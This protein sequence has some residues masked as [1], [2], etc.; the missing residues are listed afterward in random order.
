MPFAGTGQATGQAPWT[1]APPPPWV[2]LPSRTDPEPGYEFAGHRAGTGRHRNRGQRPNDDRPVPGFEFDGSAPATGRHR[3]ARPGMSGYWLTPS[4]EVVSTS[5]WDGQSIGDQSIDDQSI[6]GQGTGPR[7]GFGRQPAHGT[8]HGMGRGA[9]RTPKIAVTV[10]ALAAAISFGIFVSANN[11]GPAAPAATSPFAGPAFP[12][13]TFA[14]QDFTP[15]LAQSTRGITQLQGRVASSGNEVVAV[16]A[17]TGQL[18][19]RAQFFVSLNDGRSWTLGNVTAPGGGAPPPGYA[20]QFVA[21]GHGRWVAVGPYALWTSPDGRTWTLTEDGMP[22]RPGDRITVLKRTSDGFIAAGASSSAGSSPLVLLSATGSR[23]TRLGQAQLKLRAAGGAGA[24]AGADAGGRVA[25]IRLA[26]GDRGS[27]LIAGDVVQGGQATARTGGAWL[28]TDGGKSWTAV[29][30]PLGHGAQPEF[31]DLI[32][33]PGDG[34]LMVR[35]AV[36]RGVPAADVYQ[37]ATGTTWRFAAT[38]TTPAGFTA[39]LMNGGPDGAVL[40]GTAGRQLIVFVSRDG[41]AWRQTAFSGTAATEAVSGVAVTDTSAVIAAG[42]SAAVP[43]SSQRLVTVDGMTGGLRSVSLTAIPGA[44]E[45]QLAV[46][47]VAAHGSTQIAVGSAN[48]FPAAWV[49]QDAGVT[50]RRATGRAAGVLD[51]RGIQQLTSVT[52]GGSGWLAVGVPSHTRTM[53][54]LVL[55]SADGATWSVV[56]GEPAFAGTGLVTRQV[57]V[58]GDDYVIAGHQRLPDGRVIAAAWWSHGLA[59]W[60]RAGDGATGALDGSGNSRM[61][62]VTATAGGFAAAG[63]HGVR[64]AVWLSRDGHS[65]RRADLPLPSGASTAVLRHVAANAGVVVAVG[66]AQ[67]PAGQVPFA[68]RSADGGAT[69]D[70]SLLPKPARTVQVTAL[71]AAGGGFAATGMYGASTGHQNVVIWTSADGIH[72]TAATPAARGLA[73]PGIQAITGLDASGNLLTGVGFTATP[74]GEQPTLWH[75]RI[76]LASR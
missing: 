37:S 18:V 22:Q 10:V 50:W 4:G 53:H 65:W 56:D 70:E 74:A 25:G 38:L 5:P 20:A 61:A 52:H 45:P 35:P 64:P 40:T 33:I 58:S 59:G 47:A 76:R 19:P 15:Y 54:P 21:G 26:A 34:F 73:G 24:S 46:T 28:S 1:K 71:A 14:G 75:A 17:E 39:G 41:V 36:V 60:H 32:S 55:V 42:T 48:G 66:M 67:T 3:V 31:T 63:S 9:A 51:G 69:W 27:I 57:A 11:H 16:G 23:W 12:P 72:W 13:V 7:P 30:V 44:V 2:V 29:Q 8:V 62:A 68:V 6:G 49:S 43:G